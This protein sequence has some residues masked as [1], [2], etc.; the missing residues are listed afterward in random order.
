MGI[1]SGIGVGAAGTPPS[2]DQATAVVTGTLTAVGPGDPFAF[3]ES[4]TRAPGVQSNPA[5]VAK[6]QAAMENRSEKVF[7]KLKKVVAGFKYDWETGKV[8]RQR[9]DNDF[10]DN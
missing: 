3:I 5:L 7:A 6:I 8:F 2:G 9:A 10:G 1:P 4:T